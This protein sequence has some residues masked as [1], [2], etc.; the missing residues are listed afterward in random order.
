[1][2]YAS[3]KPLPVGTVMYPGK[4]FARLK[5]VHG[6]FQDSTPIFVVREATIQ[7]YN[8]YCIENNEIPDT[9]GATYFYEISAD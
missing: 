7:E 2:I 4:D 5:D 1:M 3:I 8:R 6:N 9:E